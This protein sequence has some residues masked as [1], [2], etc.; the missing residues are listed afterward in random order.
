LSEGKKDSNGVIGL[1]VD[2]EHYD[3]PIKTMTL[4]VNVDSDCKHLCLRQDV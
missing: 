2:L 4:M 3:Y 1:A